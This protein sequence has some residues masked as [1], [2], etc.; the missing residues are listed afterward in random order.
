ME[1]V[2]KQIIQNAQNLR[3]KGYSDKQ[4]AELVHIE[5]GKLIILDLNMI[6]VKILMDKKVKQMKLDNQKYCQENLIYT[7]ESK[8]VKKWRN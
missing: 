8:F 4:L 5:L 1:N 7:Q 2:I 6:Q 3:N